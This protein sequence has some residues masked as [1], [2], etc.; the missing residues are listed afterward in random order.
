MS[1]SPSPAPSTAQDRQTQGIRALAALLNFWIAR[2][3]WSHSAM[4]ALSDW[5]YGEPSPLQSTVISRCRNGSQA[6]GA[7]LIHLDAISELNLALWF[8]DQSP[9]AAIKRYG[10]PSSWG[11]EQQWLDDAVWLPRA[12]RPNEPLDLGDL[13]KLLAGRLTLPY[14][15]PWH[16]GQGEA[17]RLCAAV[18]PLL[19]AIASERGWGP[20][21]AT[22]RYA[23]AYPSTDRNRNKRLRELLSGQKP[24]APSELEQELPALA[25]MIRRVSCEEG[26]EY[27]PAEL[28]AELSSELPPA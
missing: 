22:R 7:G 28:L 4:G 5:S 24:L 20:G 25:E 26:V 3:N 16:I 1:P 21:E 13:A 17:A 11:I 15:A 19:D 23:A 2:S 14:L 10:L 9:A 27:G 8:Y 12:D 6:R 18:G